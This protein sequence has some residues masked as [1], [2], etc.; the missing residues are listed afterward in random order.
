M[1]SPHTTIAGGPEVERRDRDGWSAGPR[2]TVDNYPTPRTPRRYGRSRAVEHRRTRLRAGP[3]LRA[4]QGLNEGSPFHSSEMD[5][6]LHL[7]EREARPLRS[8]RLAGR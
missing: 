1:V 5:W 3:A 2:T 7:S 4:A 8:M 6:L